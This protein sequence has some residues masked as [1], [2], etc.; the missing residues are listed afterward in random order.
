VGAYQ[1]LF[2]DHVPAAVAVSEAVAQA[3]SRPHVRGFVN[4]VLRGLERKIAGRLAGDEPPPEVPS[5]RR[6]PGRTGGW[7]LLREDLL[8][9][10]EADPGGWLASA[11]SL[12]RALASGWVERHGLEAALE[13]ARA[14]NAPPPLALR[15]N[16]L[17]TSREALLEQL[18]AEG[19]GV[20]T[21]EHPAAIVL[22]AGLGDAQGAV[23]AGLA[24]VQDETA[25]A[26][27]PLCDPQPGERIVDLCAAPGGKATHLAELMGD[28]G[29]VD[30]VDVDPDRL[31]RVERAVAR[32]GLQ[33]VR[34]TLTDPGDP[35]PP[36]GGQPVDCVLA[37]VPCSNTGVLRRRVEARWRLAQ[38]DRP[39]L[40]RLQ[41]RLL[42]R[43]CDLVRPGGRVVYSTCS[44]EEEENAGQ[45]RALLGRRDDMLLE[46][47]ELT[48][49]R[50]GGG[51][52]GYRA[53][54]RRRGG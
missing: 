39:G 46:E 4:G 1:L 37:D 31:G 49:P 12:P 28:Q 30:A 35:H 18:R 50:R 8:P 20:R 29:L 42:E 25:M 3:G 33:C 9:R 41:D 14:Q 7:I 45:V 10:A 19:I 44:L 26:V 15:V 40:L 5:P 27:A 2:L 16:R 48:L 17:R 38:L 43:A 47:E 6:L 32:L 11:A 51:D 22:E 24:T 13:I 34:T 21:G 54:L 23:A 52:G 53:R 36:A